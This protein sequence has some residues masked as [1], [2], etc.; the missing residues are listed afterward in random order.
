MAK[1]YETKMV[2]EKAKKQ[3]PWQEKSKRNSPF[4]IKNHSRHKLTPVVNQSLLLRVEDKLTISPRVA[5]FFRVV[6]VN[7][8]DGL[9]LLV[10][11]FKAVYHGIV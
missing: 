7:M 8:N 10:F 6:N 11:E 4:V 3:L 5:S 1:F 9:L 2:Q